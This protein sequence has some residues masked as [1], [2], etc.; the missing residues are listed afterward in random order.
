[1]LKACLYNKKKEGSPPPS[2]LFSSHG[3]A[4][5]ETQ[6]YIIM[7]KYENM[8]G[9]YFRFIQIFT[10]AESVSRADIMEKMDLKQSAFYKYMAEC[11]KI[12]NIKNV[13]SIGG[14][15]YYSIEKKSIK[16]YFNL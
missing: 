7:S 9:K 16:K 3:N 2:L 14:N 8:G 1:M 6:N 13:G 15:T 12:F 11:R 5:V 4:K 10:E